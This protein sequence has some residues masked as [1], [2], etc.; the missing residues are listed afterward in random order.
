[1]NTSLNSL[2]ERLFRSCTGAIFLAA[3]VVMLAPASSIFAQSVEKA[4]TSQDARKQED[5]L[6]IARAAVAK[7]GEKKEKPDTGRIVGGYAVQSSIE[8]G[9]R[10]VNV[11]G[12]SDSY[13]S[14]VN[15]REGLRVLEYSLDS[16]RLDG[17][18]ALYDAMRMN[19]NNAGGDSSQTY[20]L[21]IDKARAY[22][23]DAN[24]RRFNYFRTPG[25]NFALGWRDSDLRQ[26]VSD[27]HLKLFPQRAVRVN[28]GF[29]QTMAKGRFTFP[30]S[31]QRDLFP[32]LGTT[33]WGA[34]DY[35]AGLEGVLKKWNFN[36]EV[37]YRR[38][39]NDPRL[40]NTAG[41]QTGF[42]SL[43]TDFATLSTFERLFPLR[44]RAIVTRGSAQ[45]TVGERLHLIFRALHDDEFM[46]TPFYDN[47]GGT[48]STANQL[49]QSAVF[50]ATG[51]VD[52]KN[53]NF[54]AGLSYDINKNV[55][56]NE[57]FRYSAF[58]IQ[59]DNSTRS[60]TTTKTG[61]NNPVTGTA[62]TTLAKNYIT[63][64]SSYTNTLDISFNAGKKFLAN[65][66]WRVMKRDVVVTGFYDQPSSQP[67]TT[68]PIIKNEEEAATTHA[69]IG[70]MRLRPTNRLSLIFDVEKGESNASFVRIDPLQFTRFRVRAQ[71]QAT[72]SL[73][74]IGTVTTVDRTNPTPYV[75]NESNNRSYTGAVN[76]EPNQRVWLNAGYD[77]HDL[78]TAAGIRYTL[79]SGSS[80]VTYSSN[81]LAYSRLS[82]VF[83]NG[84]IG[85]TNRLDLL[86]LYNYIKDRGAPS[87]VTLPVSSVPL[88]AGDNIQALPMFRHNPEGRIAYRFSNNF[89]GNLSYRH[90]SY[91]EMNLT[92]QLTAAATAT[93]PVYITLDPGYLNYRAGIVTA[94]MK[95]TF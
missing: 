69:F 19:V 6:A 26:Q 58:K 25:P 16:R 72:D 84:R 75:S 11:G 21:G 95:I 34:N 31:F 33:R 47:A 83:F 81:L 23:F 37:L 38:F 14:Q 43:P 57:S 9:F 39:K 42:N 10:F 74:F 68:Y 94:S 79:G 89:T 85:L 48:S 76:W 28:L 27:Y 1:M 65:L 59:G 41:V 12:N 32:V 56:I 88:A 61:S 18:G 78:Y 2:L 62:A 45:G 86:M 50:T 91:H 67:S 22:R 3:S 46:N 36:G 70:G 24:V 77:Y 54:D 7:P 20:S 63:D 90:F 64:Y 55:V 53:D 60:V 52:R 8:L 30:Y 51:A 73:S 35:R 5:E 93:V 29:G 66:G 92:R 4:E 49:I 82:S 13:R 15:V 87:G 71:I 44:S 17:T 80:A 40:Y